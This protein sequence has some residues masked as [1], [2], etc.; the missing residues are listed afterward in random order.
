M[1]IVV[2]SAKGQI[3]YGKLSGYVVDTISQQPLGYASISVVDNNNKNLQGLSTTETGLFIINKLAYGKYS[4][5]V[6]YVGYKPK[7]VSFEVL[8][9][10][11]NISP[12][13]LNLDGINLNEITVSATKPFIQQDLGKITLNVAESIMANGGSAVDILKKAPFVK[14]DNSGNI[15]LKGK[16]VVIL[17]DGKATNLSGDNLESLL[18]SL[19]SQGIDKIELISNPSA[20]YEA[21]GAAVINIRTLKMRNMGTNGTLSTGVGTGRFLRYNTGIALN[22]RKENYN[23]YGNYD[24]Q[25]NQQYYQK[26]EARTLKNNT[27]ETS[28]NDTEYDLRKRYLQS[29]KIGT[30]YYLSSN[31]TIGAL[32]SGNYN[33]RKRDVNG[34]TELKQEDLKI[35][36]DSKGSAKFANWS[37]NAN[38]KHTFD[39]TGK[40][41]SIDADY[42]NY[43]NIWK[44]S[45]SNR[46]FRYTA[47]P[48]FAQ[49]SISV[50]WNQNVVVKSI[51]ADYSNPSKIGNFDIGLQYRN[52]KTNMDFRF[53]EQKNQNW[54]KDNARSFIYDYSENVSSAYLN[55]Q[56]AINK[57]QYQAGIRSEYTQA[58]GVNQSS[59]QRNNQEYLQFFPSMSI[60]Y[61][62]SDT[63]QFSLSYSRRI[64]RPDYNE[65]NSSLQYS[66][67]YS[68]SK[69]NPLLIPS[70]SNALE[71]GYSY[72]QTWMF[73]LSYTTTKNSFM[74][75][76]NV[77]NNITTLQNQNYKKYELLSLDAM[78]Y[79]QLTK[80]WM[81]MTGVQG[82][83]VKNNLSNLGLPNLNG[84]SGYA[85][86]QNVISLGNKTKIE[87]TAY[88]QP[89]MPNG[90]FMIKS[91][92]SVDFGLQK[93]ILKDKIDMRVSVSDVF[94]TLISRYDYQ[95]TNY[96]S[97]TN[98][99]T[100][101]RFIK[102]NFVYKFGNSNIKT[103]DRKTGLDSENNRIKSN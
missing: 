21:S 6:S 37:A 24:L 47:E 44:E 59:M 1:M 38:L 89:E 58:V 77:E 81:T 82:V 97:K 62:K 67:P 79:K 41:L 45:I 31:T 75:M 51:K 46:Y 70:I 84:L 23:I 26:E 50:P 7:T 94:N 13:Y 14:V 48:L 12:I 85:Y 40:E 76:P 100:E 3:Q 88:F 39:S 9:P 16:G 25:H 64:T 57:L 17:I 15:T 80:R 90:N 101:T 78:I 27:T 91:M 8:S 69:G 72:N 43:D 5:L 68:Y 33:Q 96:S 34:I 103:R 10:E 73:N 36:I 98:S 71:L 61:S 63:N 29:Y 99:K 86:S 4:L 66:N 83:Y 30:D 32:V 53:E 19:A 52:T 20:K 42:S 56:K 2:V 35:N 65:L 11:S 18:S 102:L 22:H 92:K 54:E 93:S 87:I 55:Y 49:T 74:Y 60:N 28:F 95:A